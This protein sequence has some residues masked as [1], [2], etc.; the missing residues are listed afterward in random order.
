MLKFGSAYILKGR[1][2]TLLQIELHTKQLKL[3]VNF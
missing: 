3:G 2:V 1:G